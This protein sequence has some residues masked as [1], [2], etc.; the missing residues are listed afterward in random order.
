MKDNKIRIIPLGGL[1]EVGK[2]CTL[3]EYEDEII[4]VDFGLKFSNE[5]TPGIDFIINNTNY[6]SQ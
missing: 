3:I 5:D 6:I 4:I 2:N 1:E